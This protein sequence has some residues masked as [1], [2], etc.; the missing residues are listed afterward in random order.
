MLWTCLDDQLCIEKIPLEVLWEFA[1]VYG[2]NH[3]LLVNH[4][5]KVFQECSSSKFFLQVNET[6]ASVENP[7]LV[8]DESPN[9]LDS[10]GNLY[11]RKVFEQAFVDYV[12]HV[13]G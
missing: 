4:T 6:R 7:V 10:I 5:N 9:V 12:S 2:P 8:I 3:S 11:R 13:S 1:V